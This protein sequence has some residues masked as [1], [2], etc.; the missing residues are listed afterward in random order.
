[1]KKIFVFPLILVSCLLSCSGFP[2]KIKFEIEFARP[3]TQC[4]QH[5][6]N[7]QKSSEMI[8]DELNKRQILD[9][10]ACNEFTNDCAKEICNHQSL[11]EKCLYKLADSEYWECSQEYLLC[12]GRGINEL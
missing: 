8:P 4:F 6:L 11:S 10:C 12:H 2:K 9:A 7:P 3:P 5:V 1:M